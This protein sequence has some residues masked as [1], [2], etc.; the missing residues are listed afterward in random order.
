M[1]CRPTP[2]TD[3]RRMGAVGV[4]RLS[5][6]LLRSGSISFFLLV[7]DD[8]ANIF[9]LKQLLVLCACL[10]G[11]VYLQKSLHYNKYVILIFMASLC[12]YLLM[13]E[14][15]DSSFL[16]LF[17]LLLF[18]CYAWFYHR[19]GF[20]PFIC[21]MVCLVAVFHCSHRGLIIAAPFVTG[22][23][24]FEY[25]WIK[26]NRKG[27]LLVFGAAALLSAPYL[28]RILY[29]FFL[30]AGGGAG[31]VPAG[32][33]PQHSLFTVVSGG[34]WY[35]YDFYQLIPDAWFE[36]YGLAPAV[37]RTVIGL[38]LA[39]YFFLLAGM[40]ITVRELGRRIRKR[41]PL[42]LED[43]FG[44]LSLV[45]ILLYTLLLYRFQ[46]FNNWIYHSGFWFCSFFFIWRAVTVFARVKGIKYIFPVY[47]AV[48]LVFWTGSVVLL[49]M[50]HDRIFNINRATEIASRIAAYSPDSDIV[51][52]VDP[53]AECG[54]FGDLVVANAGH[55]VLGF[56]YRT[57]ACR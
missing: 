37:A 56:Y 32:A 11:L 4:R 51:Q 42:S 13:R 8:I 3:L 21:L 34:L 50:N 1:P 35:S 27:V 44:L 25:G 12:H 38:T 54:R 26:K 24:L 15:E 43:R 31:S 23:L 19:P 6:I 2:P 52:L 33:V 48:M 29:S 20:A 7:T 36:D 41:T 47:L 17:S 18:V 55:A 10:A 22:F 46:L 14:I 40:A 16:V 57:R 9:F 49:H 30:R 45:T 5:L 28:S 53:S 39:A